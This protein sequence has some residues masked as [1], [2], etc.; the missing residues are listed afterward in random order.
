M[1][2]MRSELQTRPVHDLT[3]CRFVPENPL[4]LSGARVIDTRGGR[5]GLDDQ[6]QLDALLIDLTKEFGDHVGAERVRKEVTR[7]HDRFSRSRIRTFVPVLTRRIA[8]EE[9]SRLRFDP[10]E[11]QDP[12]LGL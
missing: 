9:L 1:V 6:S 11:R 12:A 8:R 10:A 7:V 4:P 2:T 3:A 5:V